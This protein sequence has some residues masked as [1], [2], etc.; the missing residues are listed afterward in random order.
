MHLFCGRVTA[1]ALDESLVHRG[2]DERL[3]A[4]SLSY[5]VHD[6]MNPLTGQVLDP[7]RLL[8]VLQYDVHDK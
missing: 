1:L 5:H 3:R 7:S 6:Q 2:Q 4:I 8:N